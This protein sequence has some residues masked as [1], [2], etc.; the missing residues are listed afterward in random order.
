MSFFIRKGG[1]GGKNSL[2][3][4]KRKSNQDGRGKKFKKVIAELTIYTYIVFQLRC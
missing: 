1:T 2:I 4:K 3:G